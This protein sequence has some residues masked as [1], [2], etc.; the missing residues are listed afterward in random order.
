MRRNGEKIHID[1]LLGV[2]VFGIFAVGIIASLLAGAG[3]YK[4]L[5][6]RDSAAYDARVC[7]SYLTTKLRATEPE[8]ISFVEDGAPSG[9][10]LRISE[11]V[12]GEEYASYI[13]C[14]EGWICE[15]YT[16]GEYEPDYEFGEKLLEIKGLDMSLEKGIFNA[17]IVTSGGDRRH[18][19]VFV[20]SGEGKE[21]AE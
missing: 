10:A 8:K 3:A 7:T 1:F 12:E 11:T 15:L 20:G 16:V 18:V 4:R 6:E 9:G 2:L 17:D 19:T 21:G 14:Y 13:Y 5:T